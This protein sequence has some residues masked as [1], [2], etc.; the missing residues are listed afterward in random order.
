MEVATLGASLWSSLRPLP[1][2][3]RF[4]QRLPETITS[5]SKPIPAHPAPGAL[6]LGEATD[7]LWLEDH[8]ASLR[9]AAERESLGK[10]LGPAGVGRMI[11]DPDQLF[12]KQKLTWGGLGELWS[13]RF[14]FPSTQPFDQ[15]VLLSFYPPPP[16]PWVSHHPIPIPQQPSCTDF[17]NFR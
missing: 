15:T 9:L 3:P 17:H 1:P 4:Q 6:L 12:R 11:Y 2:D 5:P 10:L 13:S 16:A 7:N 8:R 14:C